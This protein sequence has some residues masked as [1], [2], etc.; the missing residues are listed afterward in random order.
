MNRPQSPQE[1][2]QPIKPQGIRPIRQRPLRRFVDLYKQSIHPC[3]D[4]CS[5]ESLDELRLPA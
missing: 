5:G 2:F 3:G 4:G 1:P